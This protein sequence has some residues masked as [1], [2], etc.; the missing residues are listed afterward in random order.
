MVIKI[1]GLGC[2]GGIRRRNRW[3]C[4]SEGGGGFILGCG[5]SLQKTFLF[6]FLLVYGSFLLL[7]GK[8]MNQQV[9]NRNF[10]NSLLAVCLKKVEKFSCELRLI[11]YLEIG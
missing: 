11:N 2:F 3:E 10:C 9:L 4:F 6:F 1:G 5:S 7:S 8:N